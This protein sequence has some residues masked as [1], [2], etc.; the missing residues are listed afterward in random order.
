MA[1]AARRPGAR[2]GG[3]AQGTLGR[4]LHQP[5][6]CAPNA[7]ARAPLTAPGLWLQPAAEDA[8]ADR[9]LVAL[10]MLGVGTG[11]AAAIEPRLGRRTSGS[12]GQAAPLRQS[13]P[14]PTLC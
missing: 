10:G 9:A 14:V 13:S 6:A 3:W 1:S 12:A 11:A 2:A 7:R 5:E 4:R 8:G